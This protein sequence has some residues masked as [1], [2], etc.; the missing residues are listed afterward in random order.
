MDGTG[1]KESR[2]VKA[3]HGWDRTERVEGCEG[4]S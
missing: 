3:S 2:V 4:E 1:Q